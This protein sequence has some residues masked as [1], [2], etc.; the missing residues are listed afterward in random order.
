MSRWIEGSRTAIGIRLLQTSVNMK[1]GH[2]NVLIHLRRDGPTGEGPDRRAPHDD[3]PSIIRHDRGKRE[4]ALISLH[5][6]ESRI[7][8]IR[9]TRSINGRS[10]RTRIP[11]VDVR[12]CDS[13]LFS[14]STYT[15]CFEYHLSGLAFSHPTLIARFLVDYSP[16]G[17]TLLL[18]STSFFLLSS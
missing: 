1:S 7:G 17:T 15:P 13:I 12:S 9:R 18:P 8:L 16:F 6:E 5:A 14:K 11:V 3:L 4:P 10:E 2:L